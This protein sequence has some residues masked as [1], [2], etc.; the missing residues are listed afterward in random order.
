MYQPPINA[1]DLAIA[2]VPGLYGPVGIPELLVQKIWQRRDFRQEGLEVADGRSLKVIQTGRWNRLG[3]PDFIGAEIE[4]AGQRI[5]G[6]V[7]I[8]FY[9]RDWKAHQH[10]SNPTFDGVVLH[11]VL[12]DGAGKSP[13]CRTSTGREIPLLNLAPLLMQGLEAYAMQDALFALEQTDP[14][15]LAAPLLQLSLPERRERLRAAASVRWKQKCHY[16]QK[17]LDA[18]GS[19]P[20]ACHQAALEILGYSRN[21]GPMA[22][23]GL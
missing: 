21:R 17:R 13:P 3:G 9:E 23:L 16:A 15:E 11:V 6:D 5:L 20:E 18:A 10:D 8:H 2:E 7:E 22:E 12:F 19:W 14:L 4:L 1:A